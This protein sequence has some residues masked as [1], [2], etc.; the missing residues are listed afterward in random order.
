MKAAGLL[1]FAC[2][3]TTSAFARLG[4]TQEQATT[5]YG[6]P[7]QTQPPK[8][9]QPLMEGAQELTYEYQGWKIRCSLLRA[10]DGVSYIV[11]EEYTKLP[12][13]NMALQISEDERKAILEGEG[14]LASWAERK[15]GEL[16]VNPIKLLQNQLTHSFMG[17]TWVRTADSAVAVHALGG[18]PLRLDLPQALKYEQ[19]LKAIKEQKA[20]DSVP[21]F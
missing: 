16:S 12:K 5:R 17:R 10:T 9:G 20:K 18:T 14:G 6:V 2:L 8:Y 4:E 11:R 15:T 3:T 13:P 19:E 1:L 7:K 21:K